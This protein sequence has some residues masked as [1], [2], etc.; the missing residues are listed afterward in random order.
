[1]Q[2]S[3]FV[4]LRRSQVASLIA[5]AV[6]FASMIFLVEVVHLW[7]VAATAT[8]AFAGAVVNFVLGRHWSF[9]AGDEAVHGQVF[10]YAAV[11]GASLLLNSAG[12]YLLTDRFGIHYAVSRVISAIVIG[13]IFNFPLHRH[14]VFR[15]QTYA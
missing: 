9:R 8:G 13:L 14:F 4:S 15:R 5:T 3:L 2:P 1:M 7:Y 10:R 11:S 6:D 12:V